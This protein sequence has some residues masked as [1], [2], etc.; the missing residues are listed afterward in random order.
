MSPRQALIVVLCLFILGCSK[1]KGPSDAIARVGNRAIGMRELERSFALRPEWKRGATEL[2]AHLAQLDALIAQKL[3]AQEAERLG[4]GNDSLIQRHLRFLKEKEMMRGLYRKEIRE[5]VTVD[6]AEARQMYEWSKKRVDFVYVLSPDSSRCYAAGSELLVKPAAAFPLLAESAVRTGRRTAVKIGDLPAGLERLLFGSAVNE[7]KGP[8][9]TPGGYMAVKVIG[10][11]QEK[12]LSENEFNL[13]RQKFENLLTDRKADSLSTLYVANLMGDKDLRLN[14]PVFWTV[15]DDFFRRVKEEHLDPAGVRSLNITT[16]ELRLLDADLGK[17]GDSAV[18]THRDGALT[19]RELM[20]S[21]ENMPG[22]LRPRAR[23]PENLKAAIGMIV[24][25]QYLTKEAARLGMGEDPGVL[26]EY[27]M[28]KDETLA[29]AYYERRSVEV[30]VTPEEVDAFRKSAGIS[31][32]QIFFKLNVGALARDAKTD[33]ILKWELPE[34]KSQTRIE[35][36][37][38]ALRSR[39]KHPDELLAEDP[40]RVFVREIFQ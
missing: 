38:V 34:L 1:E 22:S 39:L 21:L 27:E 5:K 8:F 31:D 37:T 26:F 36:D 10:I 3:Y 32:E 33:S 29:A 17:M 40:V 14:A 4:L 12:F 13:Q 30:R 11:T 19:V 18:A 9:R 20:A 23:T 24:R 16:D 2:G 28:Q 15:A 35:C 25:N 6:E 7:I